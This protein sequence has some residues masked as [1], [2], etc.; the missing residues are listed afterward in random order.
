MSVDQAMALFRQ[1]LPILGAL[2]VSFGWIAPE[3]VAPL[4]ANVLSIAGPAMI[5]GGAIWAMIANS[6]TSIIA[7]ASAMTEVDS[8]KL[9][10]A[11]SD[12]ALKQ[13]AKDAGT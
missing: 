4:M 5:F 10:A 12:P 9:A 1:I 3:R 6:K 7:S 13:T 8:T 11:I 2:A